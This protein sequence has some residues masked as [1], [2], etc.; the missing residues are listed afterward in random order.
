MVRRMFLITGC[1]RSGTKY[2]ALCLRAM[3]FDVGHE[4][5]R[6]DGVVSSVWAVEDA[7]YPPFHSQSRPAFD[8]V[9]HQVRHPLNCI[10]SLT[11]A[12][13]DS[14]EWNARHIDLDLSE[15]VVE[16]AASYWIQWN[17]LCEELASFTYQIETVG[18]RGWPTVSKTTNS[19]KH[20]RI[21]WTDLGLYEVEVRWLARRYGYV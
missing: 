8:L 2:M 17:L 12:R 18:A 4:A 3:G 19:R 16:V 20:R 1:G 14:W 7:F 6:D 15:S 9:L 5:P 10:A 13:K 21:D 11:T